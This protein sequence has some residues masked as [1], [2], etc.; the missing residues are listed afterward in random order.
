MDALAIEEAINRMLRESRLAVEQFFRKAAC[1]LYQYDV[2][3]TGIRGFVGM[4]SDRSD[5]I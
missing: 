4:I 3:G 2:C 5:V 1:S